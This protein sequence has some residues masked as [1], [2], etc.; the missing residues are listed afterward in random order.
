MEYFVDSAIN[1]KRSFRLISGNSAVWLAHL[2]WEQRVGGSNPS[3]PTSSPTKKTKSSLPNTNSGT[4][5]FLPRERRENAKSPRI[6][7]RILGD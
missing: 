7:F 2:L 1:K 6:F 4:T 5:N 3:C